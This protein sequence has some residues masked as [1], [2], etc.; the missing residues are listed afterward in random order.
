MVQIYL[1]SHLGTIF[2]NSDEGSLLELT[3]FNRKSFG[4]LVNIIF[5]HLVWRQFRRLYI[6]GD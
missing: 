5:P 3:G 6:P 4:F 2:E 1:A